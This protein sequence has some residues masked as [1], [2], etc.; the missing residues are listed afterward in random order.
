MSAVANNYTSPD[1]FDEPDRFGPVF[2]ADHESDDACCGDGILPGEKIRADGSGG[3]I[4][5]DTQCEEWA[6]S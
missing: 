5:A 3:W 2:T 4:H 6:R 1:L